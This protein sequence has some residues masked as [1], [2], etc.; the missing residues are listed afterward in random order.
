MRIISFDVEKVL[1]I[2]IHNIYPGLEL[3]SP[4]YCS[5]DTTCHLSPN[6]QTDIGT[7]MKASFRIDPKQKDFKGA[8]LYKLQRKYVNRDDNLPSSSTASIKNTVANVYLLVIWDVKNHSH[9]FCACLI[10]C[11][12]DFIWDED[13]LCC[14]D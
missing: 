8:L 4:L 13:K 5:N 6:Q 3:M 1:N 10:E 12:N 7:I 11:T 2:T 14:K 9:R